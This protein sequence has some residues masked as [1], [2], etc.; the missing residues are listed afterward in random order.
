M[1]ETMPRIAPSDLGQYAAQKKPQGVHH[2]YEFQCF[3]R[4]RYSLLD[5][6]AG[7]RVVVSGRRSFVDLHEEGVSELSATAEGAYGLLTHERTADDLLPPVRPPPSSGIAGHL[8]FHESRITD[9]PRRIP[10]SR[11]QARYSTASGQ[12]FR[13]PDGRQL[14][15]H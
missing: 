10:R 4:C 2:A 3:S 7:A 8:G 1:A 15:S 12:C 6:H 13:R 14:H 11:D 9:E 5:H